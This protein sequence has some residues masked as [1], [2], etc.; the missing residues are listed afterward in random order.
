MV[1]IKCHICKA[2][3]KEDVCRR[4]GAKLGASTEKLVLYSGGFT[5][6]DDNGEK[7]SK[8]AS[9]KVAITNRRL[10]IYKIK[11]EA[12]NP[13]FGLFKDLINAIKK[14]PYISIN[15]GDIERVKRYNAQHL[16]YTKNETYCIWM[17]KFKDFDE[18]FAP[19]K[20]PEEI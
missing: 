4:C 12:E 14:I 6:L 19:Y 9:C 3:N 7:L 18:F 16:I 11:P 15:F 1:R 5:Y 8:L 17:S 13:A 10:I 20:Q 2:K